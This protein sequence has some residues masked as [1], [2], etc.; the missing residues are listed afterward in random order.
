M[1][2]EK[3]HFVDLAAQYQQIKAEVDPAVIRVMTRGDFILGE[4]VT[5]FEKEFAEFCHS[6]HCVSVADGGVAIHMALRALGVGPGDE[7][8]LPSHTFIATAT[9][10]WQTGAKPVFVEVH[11]DY[12]TIDPQS[13]A[14]A[15][16]SR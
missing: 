12:Y 16:T 10:V 7:V 8:I 9:A 14:G 4:D 1:Q 11:P 6:K 15:V 5:L 2:N 13:V 3:I